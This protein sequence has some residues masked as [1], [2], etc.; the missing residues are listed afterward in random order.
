M[1]K[2]LVFSLLSVVLVSSA[3]ITEPDKKSKI[4]WLSLEEAYKLNKEYPR[5]IF[6][7]VY[8]DWCGW[9]K[10]MD[11]DTFSDADVAEF[12][13]ENYYAVKLNAESKDKIIIGQDT[14]TSQMMARSMG[15]SGYPTIVYI[16]EDFKTIQAVPGYQKADAFLDTLKKVLEWK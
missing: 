14:T 15:V 6:V 3:F 9:C 12:V 10:K 2:Y 7:D 5:K 1:K 8:T 4:N 16:K 13:N 11:R